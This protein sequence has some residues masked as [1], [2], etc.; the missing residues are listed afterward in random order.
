MIY[1]YIIVGGGVIGCSI[2]NKLTRLN[3]KCLLIEKGSDVA[4][5]TSK[6]NS[7][8]VHAGFDAM[9]GTLKATLNVKGA[10]V[11]EARCKELSVP[12]VKNGAI[13]VGNDKSVMEELYKRGQKN[14]VDGLEIINHTQL[15]KLCPNINEDIKYALY[16]KTS[17]IVSPYKLTIALAEEA[18][19]NGADVVFDYKINNVNYTEQG[20]EI[21]GNNEKFVGKQVV[22][23]VGNSHNEVASIFDTK[24]YDIVF[25]RGEYYLLDKG[26][27]DIN[28]LT[29]FPIPSKRDGK[30]VLVSPTTSGNVIVGPTSI[31]DE[32]SSPKTTRD[33]LQDIALKADNMLDNLNLKSNIRVFAGVRCVVGS[34]F[35]IEKDANH[36]NVLNVTG[37]CSPG[38]SSCFAIADYV[39][40][41][42]HENSQEKPMKKRVERP[43][44]QAKTEEQINDLIKLDK[45]FGK[46]VC[47][48]ENI[49][50]ME[51]IN[52]INSPLKPRSLDAIKRR[53]RAG[54]GRCQGGFCFMKVMEIIAE[55][56]GKPIDTVIKENNDSRIIIGDINV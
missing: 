44:I 41:I 1:D 8:I 24:K 13:V 7:G 22:L 50:E 55:E 33:G 6:A 18:V 17:A 28:G 37:I 15:R 34:D 14:G 49:S 54:M 51:I 3:K 46:I 32:D 43:T 21:S 16:A 38:L 42:L 39:A 35:V 48:C 19:I 56:T 12:Y 52:A 31:V 47:R 53:T 40:D 5:G 25:R 10:K 9:P 30:G 27:L 23:A 11:F 45:R 26:S 20:V 36:S 4:V 2:L 29:I